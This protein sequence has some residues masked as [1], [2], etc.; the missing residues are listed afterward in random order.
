MKYFLV[1]ILFTVGALLLS[2]D[3]SAAPPST[4]QLSG[5]IGTEFVHAIESADTISAIKVLPKQQ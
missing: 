2:L 3:V 4:E 1:T 5:K